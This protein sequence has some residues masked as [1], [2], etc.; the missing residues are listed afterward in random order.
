MRKLIKLHQV[1]ASVF[2]AVVFATKQ[3]NDEIERFKKKLSSI[4]ESLPNDTEARVNVRGWTDGMFNELTN[5]QINSRSM[6]NTTTSSAFYFE[7]HGSPTILF[8]YLKNSYIDW[9]TTLDEKGLEDEEFKKQ[10]AFKPIDA[11]KTSL[12][13]KGILE[14]DLQNVYIFHILN[15]EPDVPYTLSEGLVHAIENK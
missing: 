3:S 5:D 11:F 10:S 7:D 2:Y 14:G 8:D 6:V 12:L 15:Y 9:A 13:S 4:L 1:L